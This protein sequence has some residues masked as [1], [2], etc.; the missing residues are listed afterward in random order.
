ME[1]E[2][3][4]KESGV[5]PVEDYLLTLDKKLLAKTMRVIE[6]LKNNGTS[7]GMPYSKYI[8]DGIFELRSEQ[9]SNITRIMYFFV[10]G[11]K[12]VLTNGFTK[13]TS[14]TPVKEIQIAKKFRA[15][16]ERRTNGN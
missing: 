5:C 15:N 16:Y 3:Y 12:A 8:G 1:I 13:K 14:K 2:F 4:K 7:I 9:G 6:L 11:D 10:K